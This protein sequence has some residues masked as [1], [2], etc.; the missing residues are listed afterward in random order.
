[1]GSDETVKK[2]DAQIARAKFSSVVRS[3][4]W[5]CVTEAPKVW[6]GPNGK[7][8][9]YEQSLIEKNTTPLIW[10]V[11]CT[12]ITFFTFRL[13]AI[14]SFQ[15][16]RS[17]YIR[18]SVSPPSPPKATSPVERRQELQ[19]EL[20]NQA[21]SIPKD[22]LL[23]IAIGLSATA[24]LSDTRQIQQDLERVPGLPGRSSLADNMCPRVIKLYNQMPS[25]VWDQQEDEMLKSMQT[26]TKNCLRRQRLEAA[27][28]QRLGLADDQ[29]VSLPFPGFV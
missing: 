16:F 2:M 23:S 6:K 1:M 24:F 19:K 15:Q 9:I 17:K 13:S 4:V 11:G 21:L 14:R 7:D 28:R 8:Y 22:L 12:L 5:H 3:S 10:G 20:M 27:E 18:K 26:V 25:R 29:P